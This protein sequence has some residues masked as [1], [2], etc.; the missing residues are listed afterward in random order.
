MISAVA[1]PLKA[2]EIF[3]ANKDSIP[4][5][6]AAHIQASLAPQ[7]YQAHVGQA[8]SNGLADAQRSYAEHLTKPTDVADAIHQ[9]GEGGGVTSPTSVNGAVG[10]WQIMPAT[11]QQY[12]KPGEDINNPKDNEA[13]GRRIVDDLKAKYPDDPARVAVGYFSGPGNVAPPGSA[14]PWIEDKKDGNGTAVSQYV[15]K[16]EKGMGT[17]KPY[18]AN[19]DG[20][21]MTQPDYMMAHRD[22]ILQKWDEWAEKQMPGDLQFRNLVR[23]RAN[24]QIEDAYHSQEATY[25]ADNSYVI[26]AINGDMSNGKPPASYMELSAFRA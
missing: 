12:A 7:V 17:A 4:P 21:L 24:Q 22:T 16:I 18:A 15:A 1:G 13:V 9:Y 25:R 20:S 6:A 2:Q 23:T 10:G 14:T 3:D 11:F 26:R 5:V 8:F 19:P